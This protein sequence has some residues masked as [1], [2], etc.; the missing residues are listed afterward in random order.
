MAKLIKHTDLT[1]EEAVDRTVWTKERTFEIS[2]KGQ[3]ASV[4]TWAVSSWVALEI[5]GLSPVSSALTGL[6]V[7]ALTLAPK[8]MATLLAKTWKKIE[9]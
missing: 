5:L 6:A 8:I 1:A 7:T 2:F 9:H 4:A 3:A